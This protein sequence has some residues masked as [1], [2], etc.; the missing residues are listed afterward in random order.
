LTSR[1]YFQV[2]DLLERSAP[3]PG[4]T[5]PNN[6]KPGLLHPKLRNNGAIRGAPVLGTPA[7]RKPTAVRKVSF[8]IVYD[9][10]KLVS[11]TTEVMCFQ[12]VSLKMNRHS[13]GQ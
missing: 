1:A 10:S 7:A 9:P 11:G 13:G 6:P 5:H 12:R 4:A 3:T 2:R 8:C